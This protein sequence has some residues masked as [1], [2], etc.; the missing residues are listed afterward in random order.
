[1]LL[2]IKGNSDYLTNTSTVREKYVLPVEI[3]NNSPQPQ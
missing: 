1:M 3:D 2:S